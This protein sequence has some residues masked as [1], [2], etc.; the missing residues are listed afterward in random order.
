MDGF[1]SWL[2]SMVVAIFPGFANVATDDAYYGY[3]EGEYV[4]VAPKRGG[5]ITE[6][7]VA[8]GQ[9]VNAGDLLYT[10]DSDGERQAL[11]AA[12]ARFAAAKALLLDKTQGERSEELRVIE[13]KLRNAEAERD[14]ARLKYTRTLELLGRK[15]VSESQRDQ[16][17]AA[18]NMTEANVRRLTAELAVARL[19]QRDARIE[20]ARQDMTAAEAAVLRARIDLADRTVRAPKAGR[21]ERVFLRVGEFANSGAAVISL[22]PPDNIKVRFYIPEPRRTDMRVGDRVLVNCSGCTQAYPAKVSYLSS[23]VE[24]TPPVIFSLEERAKLV[25]LVEA[26]LDNPEGLLP[27]QPVDVRLAQ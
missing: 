14:L 5:L 3:V 4:Y 24:H 10:L 26:R 15:I 2:M 6:L 20:A 21:I 22:L 27:G 18:M 23:E 19:P 7:A 11:A 17:L 16:D 12:E 13:E 25:F 8:D 1:L 9:Q